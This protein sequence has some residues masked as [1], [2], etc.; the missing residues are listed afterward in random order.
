MR[1]ARI[2]LYLI[3]V[4]IAFKVYGSFTKVHEFKQDECS[5]CHVNIETDKAVLKS[6]TASV[7]EKCHTDRRQKLSHPIEVLPEKAIPADMTLVNGRM[8]CITCHFVHPFSVNNK[9]FSRYFLRRP[10]RGMF[11]CSACHKIDEK[12]HIVFE[13]IHTGSF[14]VTNPEGT[15]D[16]YTLQCI[17]CH[18]RLIDRTSLTGG[19]GKWKHFSLKLNHPVGISLGSVA[20]KKPKD[21]NPPGS[22]PEEVRLFN[23]KIGC[24]TCHNVYSKEKY[25]LVTDNF[26][27]RLCRQCHNK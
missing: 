23:G 15:L 14:K 20:A 25:M 11:F 10:G 26:K 16:D 13:K 2:I 22:L 17:E 1:Y 5:I 19:S 12:G 21:F 9:K 4:G 18:D 3:L 24:G 7:C 8:S 27:S 6:I